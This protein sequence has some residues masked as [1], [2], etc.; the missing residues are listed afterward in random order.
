MLS[1]M[2]RVQDLCKN[3][4]PSR[5]VEQVSFEVEA[6]QTLCLIGSSGS[7]KTTTLKMLNR[8]IEPSSGSIWIQSEDVLQQ[9]PVRLRRRMG[10]V[11][12]QA[13]LFPHM[14][15]AQNIGLILELEK[16]SR[17][18]IQERVNELLELVQLPPELYARRYPAELSGGQRQRVGVARAFA[19]NP[20]IILLDEPFGALDPITR[21]QVQDGF[22]DIQSRFDVTAVMVTHDMA[23]AF[24]CGHRIGIMDQGKLLQLGTPLELLNQP[25]SDFVAE[26]V[27]SQTGVDQ[28]MDLPVAKLCEAP[29]TQAGWVINDNQQIVAWTNE[30]GQRYDTLPSLSADSTLQDALKLLLKH[31]FPGLP[32]ESA[33]GQQLG[34]LNVEE[35]CKL[36]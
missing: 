32:V 1:P 26:F 33:D 9:D 36:L 7:G 18:N 19:L 24:K 17:S 4:G 34:L 6:G 20:P 10:Y 8:L 23:E 15:V 13:G 11:I 31:P 29:D 27:R 12:Q 14:S 22:L 21:T 28:L 5:A 30:Q 35:I 2:I 16:W 3:F 25:A